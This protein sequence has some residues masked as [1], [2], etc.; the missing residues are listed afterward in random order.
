MAEHI[1]QPDLLKGGAAAAVFLITVAIGLSPWLAAPLAMASYAAMVL[2]W[3]RREG[4]GAN[5]AQMQQ[6]AFQEA[7]ANAE[8]IRVLQ[9]WIAKPSARYQIGRILERTDQVLA[10]MLEDNNLTAAPLFNDHL[11]TPTRSLLMEYV[12][13][14]KREIGGAADLLEKIETQT[15]PHIERT[16]DTFYERLHRSHV[17]DLAT[18]DDVL[19]LNLERIATT[20]SR[21]LT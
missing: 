10:V 13:L 7:L 3:P 2:L 14:S 5:E 6:R 4:N 12:R 21:R 11:M 18:F 20:S 19:D 9:P 8:A 1:E 16:I 15:L 17:V